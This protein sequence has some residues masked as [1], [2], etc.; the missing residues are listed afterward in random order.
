M[1]GHPRMNPTPTARKGLIAL[2]W[3][4]FIEQTL[5]MLIGTVDTFMVSHVSD[6]AVAAV[7]VSN[8]VI[9][10][11]LIAFN[12]IG[13]GTSVVI[14]HHLGARDRP[15]ADR[16]ASSA[17]AV[18]TWLGVSFSAVVSSS[19]YRAPPS[20]LTVLPVKVDPVMRA[21]S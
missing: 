3:P 15:G 18:N 5:R 9:V 1:L 6:G 16:I 17:I 13:I 21:G 8:Q 20:V 7:G 10:F 19:L 12:F 2:A 4:I 14:T 11:F